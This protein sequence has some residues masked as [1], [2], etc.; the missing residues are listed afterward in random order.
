MTDVILDFRVESVSL[1]TFLISEVSVY[2]RE[3]ANAILFIKDHWMYGL[4]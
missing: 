3:Y 1:A 4:V 2:F